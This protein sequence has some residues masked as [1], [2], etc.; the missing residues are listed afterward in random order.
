M[1]RSATGRRRWALAVFVV[2]FV[3]HLESKVI[4]SGDSRWFIPAAVSILHHG[5]MDLD[6]YAE[7]IRAEGYYGIQ[8]VQGHF[9]NIFPPG[10]S[11]ASLPLVW[12][13]DVFLEKAAG[14]SLERLL[15]EQRLE[16]SERF[17]ASFFVAAAA[18]LMFLVAAGYLETC[19]A[20]LLVAGILAFATSAWSTASRALWQHGPSMLM[21]TAAIYLFH[22][23]KQDP[24]AIQWT[25]PVL[26]FACIIRPTNA[27]PAVLLGVVVLLRHRGY[28]LRTLFLALL[29]LLPFA[30]VNLRIYDAV[31]PPYFQPARL[32]F[33]STFIEALAGNL[34][35]P[36]RGLFVFSPILLLSLPGIFLKV[37]QRD[38]H[39]LDVA[40][41]LIL[42]L[43]WVVISAF[44]HWWAGYS[45]G[46]RLFTDVVP[47]F[48][49]FL[50]PVIR[51]IRS[52]PPAISVPGAVVFGILLF[53]SVW[54]H[55]RGANSW[56]VA[57]WNETPVSVDRD[58]SRVWDWSDLQ[59]LR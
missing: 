59:F 2:V 40:L 4:T 38:F 49:Y 54:V 44:P 10:T 48:V 25:G 37:R 32:A 39:T 45:I 12:A 31:V 23:A 34:F 51:Y 36:N 42:L 7:R 22:R 21:L 5:D 19:S 35:S 26:A 17:I 29:V 27:V 41:V 11:L 50:M 18:A 56:R 28:R 43:H 30:A 55:Y 13:L 8:K 46:P 6:E 33:D 20:A 3:A 14:L 47:I 1:L 15:Q 52:Q 58:P 53:F 9:Y 24:R 57:A 16:K